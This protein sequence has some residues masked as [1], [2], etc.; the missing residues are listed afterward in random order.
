MEHIAAI[1]GCGCNEIGCNESGV[2]GQR[3]V[4]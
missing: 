2:F 4:L 1:E 3:V